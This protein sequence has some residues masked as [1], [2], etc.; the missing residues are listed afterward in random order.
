MTP[1][2]FRAAR[3]SLGMTAKQLASLLGYARQ[4]SIY[5]I[6]AGRSQPHPAVILLMRAYLE[7]YS[8]AQRA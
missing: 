2:E 7:G 8:P 3:K 4:S 6:E 5:D 1:D